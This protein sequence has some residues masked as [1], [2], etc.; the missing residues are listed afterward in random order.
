MLRDVVGNKETDDLLE[1]INNLYQQMQVLGWKELRPWG[2]FFGGIKVPQLNIRHLEQRV[3]TN[4]LHYRS[5]YLAICLVIFLCQIFL[6]PMILFSVPITAILCFYIL[7]VHKTPV[8]IGEYV[9]NDQVKRVACAI[10]TLCFLSITAVLERLIWTA[11]YSLFVCS[12]HLILRPRSVT[13]KVNKAYEDT[14]LNMTGLSWFDSGFGTA[15]SKHNIDDSKSPDNFD[16]DPEDPV[17]RRQGYSSSYGASAA[18]AAMRKR[19]APGST[20]FS[21]A[22]E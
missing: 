9:V 21:G 3:T 10:F 7:V 12:L 5:N 2:E 18:T 6:S 19:G 4:F 8:V 16:D 14:K 17:S 22:K 15:E 20:V 13:S 1:E 11:L